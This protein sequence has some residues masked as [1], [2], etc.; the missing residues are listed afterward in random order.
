MDEFVRNEAAVV[1]VDRQA[2]AAAKLRKKK[3]KETQDLL[4]RI[5]ELEKRVSTLELLVEERIK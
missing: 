5:A 2:Y 4:Q 3:A 1:S